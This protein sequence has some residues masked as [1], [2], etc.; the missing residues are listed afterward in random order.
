MWVSYALPSEA[1]T[2]STGMTLSALQQRGTTVKG[3]DDGA[4]SIHR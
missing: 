2:E 1:E 4:P 3:S